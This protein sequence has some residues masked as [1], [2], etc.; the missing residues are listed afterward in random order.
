MRSVTAKLSNNDGFSEVGTHPQKERYRAKHLANVP[1]HPGRSCTNV[2]TF[3][4]YSGTLPL[5]KLWSRYLL[6]PLS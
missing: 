3:S 1:C 6:R 2:K 5:E 4:C